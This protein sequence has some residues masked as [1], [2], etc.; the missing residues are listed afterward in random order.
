MFCVNWQKSIFESCC[1]WLFIFFKF[2]CNLLWIWVC[3]E[4]C[5]FSSVTIVNHW[6]PKMGKPS[7]NHR[8]RWLIPPKTING[9]G[10]KFSK[11]IAIPSLRKYDHRHSI[12]TK[13]WPSFQSTYASKNS[14][15]SEDIERYCCINKIPSNNWFLYRYVQVC[16]YMESAQKKWKASF[17]L[18]IKGSDKMRKEE[19]SRMKGRIYELA[20]INDLLVTAESLDT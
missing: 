12:A 20:E 14:Q 10:E 16:L 18:Q 3:R 11:T 9:D 13:N 4:I 6:F 8:C 15:I 1:V 7:K 19:I 5:I 2:T 17:V